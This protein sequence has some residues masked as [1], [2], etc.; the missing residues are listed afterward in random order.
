MGRT[1]G[2]QNNGKKKRLPYNAYVAKA[3][4][5][6]FH[7]VKKQQAK[8][9]RQKQHV[10]DEVGVG[11]KDSAATFS[12]NDEGSVAD[13]DEDVEEACAPEE[14][15]VDNAFEDNLAFPKRAAASS[16]STS[17]STSSKKSIDD[18]DAT[19]TVRHKAAVVIEGENVLDEDEKAGAYGVSSSWWT[20]YS[21]KKKWR[22]N[23]SSE[24]QNKNKREDPADGE[25]EDDDRDGSRGN[26]NKNRNREVVKGD[27]K[28]SKGQT[29]KLQ[30]TRYGKAQRQLEEQEREK[31][32]LKDE[33]DQLEREVARKKKDTKNRR[34]QKH[35]IR[36][37]GRNN[38]GQPRMSN[39]LKSLM[40]AKGHTL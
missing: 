38:K 5:E 13:D 34:I 7:D 21:S 25:D 14:G 16:S 19:T 35:H 4:Q 10:Y 11:S 39:M 12:R 6:R 23:W 18:A 27:K 22:K 3:R 40:L 30:N 9:R 37:S 1:P 2:V 20:D 24:E 29:Q 28:K 33:K 17:S 31:Q 36:D 32:R 15:Q 8:W 26:K